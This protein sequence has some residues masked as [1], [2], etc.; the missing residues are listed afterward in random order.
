MPLPVSTKAD[1]FVANLLAVLFPLVLFEVELL[2]L[3]AL[4]L[5]EEEFAFT[6]DELLEELALV[7]LVELE[8]LELELE[9]PLLELALVPL[10][11]LLE[12]LEVALV[13]FDLVLFELLLLVELPLELDFA[14][15]EVV[16]YFPVSFPLFLSPYS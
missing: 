5:F 16:A 7:P 11:E 13:V 8:L 2:E 10:V 6:L 14:E 1:P 3:V 4:E 9:L 12:L 15:E